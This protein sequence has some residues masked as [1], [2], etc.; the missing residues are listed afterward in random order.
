[1]GSHITA[2]Y[3]NIR[4]ESNAPNIVNQAH[5]GD[6]FVFLFSQN[7]KFYL[8]TFDLTDSYF[9]DSFNNS[10][11]GSANPEEVLETM[12]EDGIE[13]LMYYTKYVL[14][15]DYGGIGEPIKQPTYN[16]AERTIH[17]G[18]NNEE[19]KLMSLYGPAEPQ[20][21]FSI[22]EAVQNTNVYQNFIEV[23][24]ISYDS[25]SSLGEVSEESFT[26]MATTGSI[27]GLIIEQSEQ[28]T[29]SGGLSGAGRDRGI[30]STRISSTIASEAGLGDGVTS[31]TVTTSGY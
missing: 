6:D 19:E 22:E 28:I 17:Y 10:L 18:N 12:E 11:W 26:I 30:T 29:D 8:L 25:L 9:V 23:D 4:A 2:A 7:R 24:A 3:E 5:F 27:S 1:M 16:M 13:F 21:S 20:I 14:L 15:K 31:T